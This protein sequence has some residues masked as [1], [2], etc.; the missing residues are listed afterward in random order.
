[1][2]YFLYFQLSIQ[3]LTQVAVAPLMVVTVINLH[4]SVWITVW[5]AARWSRW[6]IRRTLSSIALCQPCSLVQDQACIQIQTQLCYNTVLYL[7]QKFL[8]PKSFINILVLTSGRWGQLL[9]NYIMN[10]SS[11]FVAILSLSSLVPLF[12]C[13]VQIFRHQR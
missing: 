6:T 3:V 4:L 13:F 1:M 12:A 10:E 9:S 11:H 2:C 5:S 7:R 8:G